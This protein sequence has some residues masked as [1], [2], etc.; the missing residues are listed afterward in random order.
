MELAAKDDQKKLTRAAIAGCLRALDVRWLDDGRDEGCVLDTA[1]ERLAYVAVL[2]F[3]DS[4]L[5]FLAR[6]GDDDLRQLG[7]F[8][9]LGGWC[10][11][12]VVLRI[13]GAEM[14]AV[15]SAPEG[16]IVIERLARFVRDGRGQDS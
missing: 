14:I 1:A 16:D 4:A 6:S 2:A 5:A 12:Y 15:L 9:A 7:R 11:P 10:R 8:A 3:G 13:Y